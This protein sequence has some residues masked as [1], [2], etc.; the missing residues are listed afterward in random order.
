MKPSAEH[1]VTLVELLVAVAIFGIVSIFAFAVLSSSRQSAAVN[2]QTVQVQQ[3]VRL[4]MDLIARDIRMGGFGYPAVGSVAGCTN[5]INASAQ[6][7]G[8]PFVPGDNA[9]GADA[10][11]DSIQIITVDQQ[12]G[13][14]AAD[15]VTGTSFTVN[16]LAPDISAGQVLT[17]EGLF[18]GSV[19][20]FTLGS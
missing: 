2:D 6:S 16:N 11:S 19:N 20:A 17:I 10:G 1:G 18:T 14:L 8:P 13:T 9:V 7:A 3:N 12:V 5:H 15:Y 4:A